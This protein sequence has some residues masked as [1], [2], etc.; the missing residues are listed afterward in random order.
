MI[1]FQT[2]FKTVKLSGQKVQR[3][4]L[5]ENHMVL[6]DSK[7]QVFGYGD[8]RFHQL[9]GNLGHLEDP[10]SLSFNQKFRVERLFLGCDFSFFVDKD[11]NVGC[12]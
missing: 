8:N 7:D 2:D 4:S 1:Q 12:G 9:D 3:V 6:M 11:F 5:G 10:V